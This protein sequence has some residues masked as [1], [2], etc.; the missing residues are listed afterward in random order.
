[1]YIISACLLGK[2]CKYDGGNNDTEWV[3]EFAESHSFMPVCP[4]TS[5]GLLA[6]REPC[7]IVHIAGRR[8]VK[9]TLG[10]DLTEA[11]ENGAEDLIKAAHIAAMLRDEVIEGAILKSKSPSCGA[12]EIY[13]GTFSHKT[14]QGYGIFAEKLQAIGIPIY[15]ENSKEQVALIGRDI[16]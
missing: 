14:V 12:G 3:R 2:N 9:N 8:K 7:E 10:E 1:M 16:Y 13:D 15:N 11:F 4:E 5:G 6:P